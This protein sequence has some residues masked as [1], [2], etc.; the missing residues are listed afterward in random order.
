MTDAWEII[1]SAKA[2]LLDF[3][4]PITA[5]MPPPLNAQAADRARVALQVASL[6]GEIL[7][8]TDHLAVLRFTAERYPERFH[9]VERAC[10]E[11]EIDCARISTPSPEAEDLIGGA[12]RRSVPVAIVSNNS[13]VAVQEFLRRFSWAAPVHVL[14]CRTPEVGG[15]LKPNPLLVHRAL[16]HL[17]VGAWG[18]VFVGDSVSDVES[19]NSAGVRVV[20][21]SKTP[22]RGRN[23]ILAGAVALIERSA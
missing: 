7:T 6:P 11:A 10:S 13:E 23:L 20:G 14:A 22:E 5:L 17:R 9:D 4:G 2:L 1:A 16:E 12:E 15:R 18:A 3:D 8:T 21:L 19:G